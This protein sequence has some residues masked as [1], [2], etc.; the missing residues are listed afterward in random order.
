MSDLTQCNFCQFKNIIR[1]A[2][3]NGKRA[4]IK[5]GTPFKTLPAGVDVYVHP[6]K[7]IGMNRFH[8]KYKVAWFMKLGNR[9][10][11]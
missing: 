1:Q 11:C 4:C 10:E 8:K 9:C 6:E 7:I 5:A 2:R 3:E